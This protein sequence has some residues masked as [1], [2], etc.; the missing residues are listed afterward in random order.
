MSGK[1][2]DAGKLDYTKVQSLDKGITDLYQ[3]PGQQSYD[4]TQIR[5]EYL[6]PVD[7]SKLQN[8]F[9]KRLNRNSKVSGPARSLN[10][11][12]GT[13][14]TYDTAVVNNARNNI[15]QA[16]Q[17]TDI[18]KTLTFDKV[19]QIGSV[20]EGFDK[21]ARD[22]FD[23]LVNETYQIKNGMQLMPWQQGYIDPTDG[24]RAVSKINKLF[25][26]YKGNISQA[27]AYASD[28]QEAYKKEE[29]EPGAVSLT[30]LDRTNE[31]KLLSAWTA[32]DPNV[33]LIDNDGETALYRPSI[34]G[35]PEAILN[36]SKFGSAMN[37]EGDY[38]SRVFDYKTKLDGV[39]EQYIGSI[40][41][42][43]KKGYIPSVVDYEMESTK[44]GQQVIKAS[45]V[46]FKPGMYEKS[47]E[48]AAKGDP[49]IQRILNNPEHA[50]QMWLDVFKAPVPYNPKRDKETLRNLIAR[51]SINDKGMANAMGRVEGMF[52]IGENGEVISEQVFVDAPTVRSTAVTE[53]K[54]NYNPNNNPSQ[55]PNTYDTQFE[56][57]MEIAHD[58]KVATNNDEV[59]NALQTG[60]N[61]LKSG[62]AGAEQ[63]QL[64]SSESGF[65]FEIPANQKNEAR[66]ELLFTFDQLKSMTPKRISEVINNKLLSI[67]KASEDMYFNRYDEAYKTKYGK[68]TYF[69]DDKDEE[70][71]PL[72]LQ[73]PND[74][75]GNKPKN[76]KAWQFNYKVN[77]DN[78]K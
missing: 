29:G 28:L 34:N 4:G 16:S 74:P 44:D 20:V 60:F 68:N 56:Q 31:A 71:T 24:A 13:I 78:S 64:K 6:E 72:M 30:N 10:T 1:N 14:V 73:N 76:W 58:V 21:N 39:G 66:N 42:D 55:K 17:S 41:E 35:N 11:G 77:S 59:T 18:G 40:S 38:I 32:G 53:K 48:A 19:S 8:N 49:V 67:P 69:K 57:L 2:Q 3:S 23:H 51:K 12:V 54:K 52:Q 70:E 33:Y 7:Y 9:N 15:N 46:R 61:Q 26:D 43:G 36:L 75:K 63:A 27:Y 45:T 25:E 37:Q 5:N 22:Y 50:R 47:V 65:Y 62:I